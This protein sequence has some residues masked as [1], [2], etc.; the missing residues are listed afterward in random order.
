MNIA[1]KD[2]SVE[3]TA[4]ELPLGSVIVGRCVVMHD[5]VFTYQA[6][7]LDTPSGERVAVYLDKRA[8]QFR[9]I[10]AG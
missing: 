4:N 1:V 8:N 5:D 10:P 7:V 9:I 2:G 3:L 6:L